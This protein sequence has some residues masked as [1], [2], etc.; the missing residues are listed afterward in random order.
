VGVR[1]GEESLSCL[2]G[3]ETSRGKFEEA[4]YNRQLRMGAAG[5]K[6]EGEILADI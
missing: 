1:I 4:S 5:R 3:W 2:M 6:W